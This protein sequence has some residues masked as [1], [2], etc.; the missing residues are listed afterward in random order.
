MFYLSGMNYLYFHKRTF[1][2]ILKGT[3]KDCQTFENLV[4]DTGIILVFG[5]CDC[6][7]P[8]SSRKTTRKISP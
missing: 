6:D 4:W 8:F 1:R 3:N 7:K 5:I 2:K